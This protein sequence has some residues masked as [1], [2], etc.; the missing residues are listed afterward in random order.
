MKHTPHGSPHKPMF[1]ALP[2]WQSC[3]AR[4]WRLR[5]RA[6]EVLGLLPL[7]LAR[8]DGRATHMAAAQE[9]PSLTCAMRA[10]SSRC[11]DPLDA[12]IASVAAQL[13]VL[14]P[15]GSDVTTVRA[16]GRM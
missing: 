12:G 14:D 11:I 16:M 10:G 1:A 7:V 3:K 6:P 4:S 13:T 8:P 9:Q 15:C 5:H 2:G